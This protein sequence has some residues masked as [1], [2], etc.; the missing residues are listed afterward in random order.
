MLHYLVRI[1]SLCTLPLIW[2][3]DSSLNTTRS[4]KL[5]SVIASCIVMLKLLRSTWSSVSQTA[6]SE[7]SRASWAVPSAAPSTQSYST[8]PIHDLHGAQISSDREEKTVPLISRLLWH[9]RRSC[10]FSFTKEPRCLKLLIPASN[11]IGRW[12]MTVEFSPECLLNR[13]NWFLLHKLQHT[14]RFRLQSRHYRF[15]TSQTKREEGS[16]IAHVHKTWTPAVSIHV[17]NL[18][19]RVLWKP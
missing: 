4:R 6:T 13:N 3:V 15:V 10:T 18:L 5:S 12:G 8:S 14:K 17:G 19:L 16:G 11:A 9:T 7:D 2:N 1:F